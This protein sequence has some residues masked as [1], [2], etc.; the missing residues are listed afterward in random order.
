MSGE[1]DSLSWMSETTRP[2][3]LLKLMNRVTCTCSK[4]IAEHVREACRR[5]GLSERCA[6]CLTEHFKGKRFDEG[7]RSVVARVRSVGEYVGRKA[8]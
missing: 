8:A 5:A 1:S 6:Y 2:R 3:P 4:P 7:L